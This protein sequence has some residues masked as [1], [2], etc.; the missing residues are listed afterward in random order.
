MAV[1]GEHRQRSGSVSI[2][3]S[4]ESPEPM[5]VIDSE[6]LQILELNRAT[7]QQYGY[8]RE[9]VGQCLTSVVAADDCNRVRES[10]ASGQ[11]AAPGFCEVGLVLNDGQVVE[12]DLY[13]HYIRYA[14]KRAAIILPQ[15]SAHRKHLEEQ[16]R[17][18]H[19]MESLGM[20]AGGI[21][22]DFNNLLTIMNGY[23]QLLLGSLP[24][25]D[26]NRI[27][28]EQIM[29]AGERAAELTRQLLTFSRRQ[30]VRARDLDLN[31][32]VAST[33]VML[34]RLIGEHIE[35]R[36][37]EGSNVG[38]IHADPGQIE[39]V[40]LNLAVNSRDAMP[41]G[42]TLIL[43]TQNVDL[44]VSSI[45]PSVAL[46]PG[47]YVMLAVTDTGVGMDVYTLAHLF[48]PFF[49][50]KEQGHGTGLG[51]STVQ[52]IV[53]QSGGEITVH[54]ETGQGT[55][56]K[57]Y[58][59]RAGE[60]AV[61]DDRELF[62]EVLQTG[63][64]TILLVEDD[65]AVRM[66]V[67]QTLEKQGY[68]VLA[69]AS[70]LEALELA[71]RHRGQINLLVADVVMPQMGGRQLARQLKAIQPDLA[72]LFMSGYTEGAVLQAGSLGKGESFLAKPFTP[73]TL[74]RRVRE[75]LTAADGEPRP[76]KTESWSQ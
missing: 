58:F 25:G 43:E 76:P 8:G 64:E 19:K 36:I 75:A 71:R 7:L 55:C 12:T 38:K 57:V 60:P 28:V 70:G 66:L 13:L 44:D 10:V 45:G 14:G 31:T 2:L 20:L 62:P 22:H 46:K 48:E 41:D 50:T 73:A 68:R 26:E 67:S 3:L 15:A 35:L 69:A 52:G 23:S 34:R 24:A 65:D 72:V 74:A 27:A 33:A 53:K 17:Q 47:R 49:T 61:A 39:Q 16:V 6:T 30:G 63:S 1:S 21:A 59:P 51:L 5:L 54:S 4:D 37:A 9:L 11:T 18:A 42:G 32:L 56:V 29:K 40:I